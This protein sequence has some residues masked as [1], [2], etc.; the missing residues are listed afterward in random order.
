MDS[1]PMRPSAT[2]ALIRSRS[3]SCAIASRTPAGFGSRRRWHLTTR[4]LARSRI[5]LPNASRRRALIVCSSCS[6]GSSV[7][8]SVE[9]STSER[10]LPRTH[11]TVGRVPWQSRYRFFVIGAWLLLVVIA[12]PFA[13]QEQS[14]LTGGGFDAPGSEAAIVSSALQKQYPNINE[15]PLALVLVPAAGASQTDMLDAIGQVARSIDGIDGVSI[16]P[17]ARAQV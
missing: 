17:Q 2:W 15:S 8:M 14:H 12:A 10:P 13:A 4:R 9:V 3:S 6:S 1:V 16:N 5:F 7:S 11:V